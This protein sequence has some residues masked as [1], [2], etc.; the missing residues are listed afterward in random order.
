MQV[1]LLA[2]LA[3]AAGLL[4]Q[5]PARA[6]QWCPGEPWRLEWGVNADDEACHS[7]PSGSDPAKNGGVAFGTAPAGRENDHV[8]LAGT[9]TGNAA[10]TGG[11][12]EGGGGSSTANGTTN[13]AVGGNQAG[14]ANGNQAG[15]NPG[16]PRT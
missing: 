7:T 9:S 5:P 16:N 15:S 2:G 10:I 8:D 11:N 14:T 3:V 4:A 6:S 13:G 12:Q 1:K